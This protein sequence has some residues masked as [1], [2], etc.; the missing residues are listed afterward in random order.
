[1][2][3]RIIIKKIASIFGVKIK[4]DFKIIPLFKKNVFKTVYKKRVLISYITDPFFIKNNL[5]HTNSLECYTSAKIF[6]E[7]GFNVDVIDFSSNRSVDYS[8]Y[9]IIYGMGNPFEKSFYY[10]GTPIKRIFYATGCN[11]MYSNIVTILKVRGLKEK[12]NKILINSS[13]FI[14]SS[15]ELQVLLSDKVIILGNSFVLDTYR[16]FDAEGIDRYTNLNAFFYDVYNPDLS[17]KDFSRA[18]KHFLW[19]GSSGLLHKGLD[20]LIDIFSKRED[21]YL[22]ICGASDNEKE[23]FNYYNPILK[24]SK[25]IF[26]HGFVDIRS[27]KYNRIVD[28]CTFTISPSVS[29]GGSPAVLNT[30]ANGGL[31]PIITKSS[32][33]DID[34][35]G[36]VIEK[37]TLELVANAIDQALLLNEKKLLE[38]STLAKNTI[39]NNYT[40]EDYKK[41]LN[42]IITNITKQL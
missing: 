13:R 19:F 33:L 4:K 14:H 1:M 10:N 30:I 40:H 2:Q 17:K 42:G 15:P 20:L 7:L 25:N 3:T 28:E 8:K 38:M 22:H 26:N 41:N 34:G 11:P 21:I 36:I 23:F 16:K 37:P 32:S 12:T 6:N 18:K 39:R 24:K 35:F 27:N 31:I 9:D 5:S 29:E